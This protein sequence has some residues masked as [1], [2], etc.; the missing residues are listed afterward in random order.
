MGNSD[1]DIIMY[2]LSY[3]D[4]HLEALFPVWL[5]LLYLKYNKWGKKSSHQELRKKKQA[6]CVIHF[7]LCLPLIQYKSWDDTSLDGKSIDIMLTC[8]FTIRGNIE[9]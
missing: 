3:V 2:V 6:V 1:F 4:P 9:F 7:A 5:M 8:D